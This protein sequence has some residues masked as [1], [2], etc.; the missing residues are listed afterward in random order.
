[1]D[2]TPILNRELLVALRKRQTW[3]SRVSAG[4]M[5]LAFGLATFGA[6]Y[7]WDVGKI[8]HHDMMARAA[9]QAFLWMLPARLGLIFAVFAARAALAIA[10]EKDRRTFDFLL[11]TSLNN[12]QIVLGKLVACLS[13]L[14]ADFAVGL[15]I[16][17]LLH[18]LG[19]IDL[20][21]ILL[22]YGGLLTTGFFMIALAVWVSSGATRPRFAAN[23]AISWWLGWLIVP[24]VAARGFPGFRLPGPLVS[25]NAWVLA[26]SPV[27]IALKIFAGVGP[28]SQL[29]EAIAWMSGLQ[30]AA[31]A[32]LVIWAIARLRSAFRQN[33]SGDSHGI[34]GR[35]TRPNWRW[36]PKP[37]IGDDPILWREMNLAPGGLLD[38][39]LIFLIYL[40]LLSVVVYFTYFFTRPAWSKC[41]GTATHR[42][43]RAT[44]APNGTWLSGFSWR[45]M[46]SIRRPISRERI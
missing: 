28:S 5:L 10:D 18:S 41:G 26:S 7:Y 21:L 34:T 6:R 39:I 33:A 46:A 16:M 19:G 1:M 17:L 32:L 24:L 2:I 8:P 20:P 29:I 23:A 13:F 40:L 12:A 31:G 30:V 11:A 43:L 3:T 15:P 38:A 14:A 25:A 4:G 45:I 27:S 9:H 44:N 37:P 35:I 42:G 36:R 22:A